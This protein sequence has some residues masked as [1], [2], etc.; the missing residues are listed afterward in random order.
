MLLIV[1]PQST[2]AGVVAYDKL[3][4]A[5]K[6]KSEPLSGTPGS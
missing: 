3:T 1:A 5:L 4:G 6:W 2:E